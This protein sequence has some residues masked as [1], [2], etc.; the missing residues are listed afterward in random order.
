MDRTLVQVLK[1]SRERS[2]ELLPTYSSPEELL[3]NDKGS[4]P[5]PI[6]GEVKG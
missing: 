5:R 6:P 1:H 3:W 2:Q 4:N